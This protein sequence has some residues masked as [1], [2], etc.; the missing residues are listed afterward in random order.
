MVLAVRLWQRKHQSGDWEALVDPHLLR[1]LLVGSRA[2]GKA[3]P[4]L[5]LLFATGLA[6]GVLALAGPTWSKK[7]KAYRFTI[8]KSYAPWEGDEGES[9]DEDKDYA[10][11]RVWFGIEYPF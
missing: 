8:R 11:N 6:L 3:S 10:D 1:Y 9:I 4:M 2:T 7:M 5:S